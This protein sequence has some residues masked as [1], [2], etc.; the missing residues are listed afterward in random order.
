MDG[1]MNSPKRLARTAGVLYLLVAILGAFAMLLV[2]ARMYVAGDAATTAGNLVANAG[3]VRAGVAADL[4]Q[5]TLW[6]FVAMALYLLLKHVSRS[7]ASAMVVFAAIGAGITMLNGVFRFESLRVAT[8]E[9]GAASDSLALLLLDT[10]HYGVLIAQVFFGLWLVPMGYV[11]YKSGWFPKALGVLLIVGGA[12]YLVDTLALFL[13]PDFGE[14][15]SAYVIIPAIIAEVWMVGYLLVIG[16]R[17]A[18]PAVRPELEC[19]RPVSPACELQP[20]T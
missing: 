11:A 6:V 16:V 19:A 3:L 20:A 17:T 12:S 1:I 10:Q 14:A 9:V 13:F 4:I 18:R 15:I 2:D 8:G 5:A 7:A